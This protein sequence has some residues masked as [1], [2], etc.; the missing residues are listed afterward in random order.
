M[1]LPQRRHRVCVLLWRLPK[2]AVP[3][4]TTC[5]PRRVSPR[6]KP[7][8]R[9]RPDSR[10]QP[11]PCT[12]PRSCGQSRRD[13]GSFAH[14]LAMQMWTLTPSDN[15]RHPILLEDAHRRPISLHPVTL[16]AGTAARTHEAARACGTRSVWERR[17]SRTCEPNFKYAIASPPNGTQR[18][19][20]GSAGPA[21]RLHAHHGVSCSCPSFLALAQK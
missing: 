14:A 20:S 2:L 8:D 1:R 13:R 15:P 12:E 3:L 6:H 7:S 11:G 4:P 21:S 17:P 9:P 5:C 19:R 16:R 10:D 18:C